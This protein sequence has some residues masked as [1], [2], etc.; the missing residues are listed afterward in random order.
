MNSEKSSEIDRSI[1]GK[2]P[3]DNEPDKLQWID[4]ETDLDCLIVR[5]DM[6][7]LCGY[8]GVTEGHPLYG[9]DYND[10]DFS[11]HGGITYSN[12]C[13]GHICHVPEPGRSDKV[14]WFGFDCCH[15]F[16]LLPSSLAYSNP[17]DSYIYRDIEYV[18]EE[19]SKLAKQLKGV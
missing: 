8:V 2:G 10:T 14:Y 5:N 11:V 7:A 16:D 13:N 15:A 6:G 1:W 9:K 18:K 19:C 4:I 3:W 12:F 17:P